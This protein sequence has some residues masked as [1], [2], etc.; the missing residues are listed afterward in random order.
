MCQM[1]IELA[2]TFMSRD[3]WVAR[4]RTNRRKHLGSK[5]FQVC[6]NIWHLENHEPVGGTGV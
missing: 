5:V 6:E 2:R 3:I 1:P 4:W